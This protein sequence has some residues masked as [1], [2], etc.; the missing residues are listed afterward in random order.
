MPPHDDSPTDRN[1]RPSPSNNGNRR[2]SKKVKVFEGLTDEERRQVRQE[3]RQLYDRLVN[4]EDVED[5]RKK[6]N[7]LFKSSVRFTREA[8]LDGDITALVTEKLVKQ[9]EQT[10]QVRA[11]LFVLCILYIVL[12]YTKMHSLYHTNLFTQKHTGPSL[13]P[14][15]SRGCVEEKVHGWYGTQ[16]LF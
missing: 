2:R 12:L 4:D 6:N 13:R 5:V 10:V 9:V 16:L 3:Q 8:V 15:S 14:K 11:L 7:R 1:K